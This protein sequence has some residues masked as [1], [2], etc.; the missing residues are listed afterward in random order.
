MGTTDFSMR[1]RNIGVSASSSGSAHH[2]IGGT[3]SSIYEPVVST[4]YSG[5]VSSMIASTLTLNSHQKTPSLNDPVSTMIASSITVNSYQQ[6]P[7]L[8]GLVDLDSAS[9]T[10]AS[11]ISLNPYQRTSAQNGQLYS[12]SI[13]ST[14]IINS[15]IET[16]HQN[17]PTYSDSV[18]TTI[19]SP[20]TTGSRQD[21]SNRNGG[22]L[23][24]PQ[25]V[26][27]SPTVYASTESLLTYTYSDKGTSVL[28]TE[29][30]LLTVFESMTS[31]VTK[32]VSS[33]S[34]VLSIDSSIN[35]TA[36]TPMIMPTTTISGDLVTDINDKSP[37]LALC[38]CVCIGNGSGS[39]GVQENELKEILQKLFVD[40]STLSSTRRK[41]TS[42]EDHRPSAIITGRLGM[43][44][45]V[46]VF[47]FMLLLDSQ[48][49]IVAILDF[50][51]SKTV[52]RPAIL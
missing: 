22:F 29:T 23:L 40:K 31:A 28:S 46:G 37:V 2:G 48:R 38:E 42:A 16:S 14:I 30:S 45:L 49:V 1:S 9:T 11:I 36:I 18:I 43:V 44:V 13:T 15:D 4:I 52:T 32:V 50:K 26:S 35:N 10:T 34:S 39:Y 19:T 33:A 24:Q 6:T 8:D 12:D 25:E 3:S 41:L 51:R 5:S 21:T 27:V 7:N 20:F 47:C 17:S